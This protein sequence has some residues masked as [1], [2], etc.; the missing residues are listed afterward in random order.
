MPSTMMCTVV[1]SRA[2]IPMSEL[3]LPMPIKYHASVAIPFNELVNTMPPIAKRAYA[4]AFLDTDFADHAGM[5]VVFMPG[6]LDT[7]TNPRW[8]AKVFACD[9]GSELATVWIHEN[10]L[11]VTFTDKRV[12][13]DDDNAKWKEW[14]SCL[15]R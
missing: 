8:I 4:K 15:N 1:V 12:F 10:P 2:I 6:L 3:Q 14:E 13:T 9:T 11:G 5:H 7:D